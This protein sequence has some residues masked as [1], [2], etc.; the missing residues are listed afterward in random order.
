[1]TSRTGGGTGNGRWE[2]AVATAATQGPGAPLGA[3]AAPSRA[4]LPAGAGGLNK[5]TRPPR[6][7]R[8]RRL[9]KGRVCPVAA[10]SSVLASRVV[11]AQRL[12]GTIPSVPPSPVAPVVG[13][14]SRARGCG[15][16]AAPAPVPPGLG[17]RVLINPVRAGE[18]IVLITLVRGQR[19][20]TG[21]SLDKFYARRGPSAQP[22][23]PAR[24]GRPGQQVHMAVTGRRPGSPEGSHPGAARG[25]QG[26]RPP[27]ER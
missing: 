4:P 11:T 1:M 21:H 6:G 9:G 15:W 27:A 20:L 2:R 22:T 8:H 26:S 24:G 25:C 13:R 23:P 5:A 12:P 17:A 14:G 10:P 3:A 18:R 16:G 7:W 19:R